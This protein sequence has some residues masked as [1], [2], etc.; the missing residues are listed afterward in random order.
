MCKKCIGE[1]G[2]GGAK[3]VGRYRSIDLVLGNTACVYSSHLSLTSFPL[4]PLKKT[5]RF[6]LVLLY[7]VCVCARAHGGICKPCMCAFEYMC[8]GVGIF[9]WKVERSLQLGSGTI[10]R[11][12]PLLLYDRPHL[13]TPCFGDFF[14]FSCLKSHYQTN[15][16]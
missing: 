11:T 13:N 14:F 6:L 3:Q 15:F 8:E 4:H 16:R 10:K 12:V 5:A 9:K 7:G 1:N 2:F